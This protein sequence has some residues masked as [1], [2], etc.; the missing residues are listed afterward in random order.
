MGWLFEF[1]ALGEPIDEFRRGQSPFLLWWP[2]PSL[3]PHRWSRTARWTANG[4]CWK[5]IRETLANQRPPSEALV[6]CGGFHLFLDRRIPPP[7]PRS[8]GHL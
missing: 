8:P 6:V 2:A 3:I 5:T 4:S 7:P 1:G